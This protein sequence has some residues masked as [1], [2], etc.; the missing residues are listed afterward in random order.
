MREITALDFVV[1]AKDARKESLDNKLKFIATQISNQI[2]NG[3]TDLEFD[4]NDVEFECI[5]NYF[6]PFGYLVQRRQVD[7]KYTGGV[8]YNSIISW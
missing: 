4:S 7:T 3:L 5:S 2:N 6:T 8:N 1:S